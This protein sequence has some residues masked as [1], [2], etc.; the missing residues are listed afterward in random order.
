[1]QLRS[2]DKEPAFVNTVPPH[3]AFIFGCLCHISFLNY[4]GN[5]TFYPF[6][7]LLS[8]VFMT[9]KTVLPSLALSG[10]DVIPTRRD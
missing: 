2:V 7:H 9:R 1:M 5:S 3:Y 4:R 8:S 6:Y 10:T